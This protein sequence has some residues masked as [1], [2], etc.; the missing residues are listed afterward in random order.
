MINGK[1]DPHR[2]VVKKRDRRVNPL[3]DPFN[4]LDDETKKALESDDIEPEMKEAILK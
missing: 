1:Y 3:F 2:D 4:Y